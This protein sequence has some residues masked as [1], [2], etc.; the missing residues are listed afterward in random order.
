VGTPVGSPV[1]PPVDS[2][3]SQPSGQPTIQPS[4]PTFAPSRVPTHAPVAPG[5]T[6]V[7]EVSGSTEIGGVSGNSNGTLSS[8]CINAFQTSME[9]TSGAQE[10]DVTGASQEDGVRRRR[11]LRIEMQTST[12]SWIITFVD[13]YY[14]S[15]YPGKNATYLASHYTAV[16]HDAFTSGDFQQLLRDNALLLNVTELLSVLCNNV[17]LTSSVTP[18]SVGPPSHTSTASLTDGQI[19][20]IVIGVVFGTLILFAGAYF[21]VKDERSGS[22]VSAPRFSQFANEQV[23]LDNRSPDRQGGG[24][25]LIDE[26]FTLHMDN[27]GVNDGSNIVTVTDITSTNHL[28]IKL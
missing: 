14:L 22:H 13:T 12:S 28:E 4:A 6:D 11:S 5:S 18:S 17:N 15:N 24:Q 27:E 2:P 8:G 10:V 1:G 23:V 3:S 9:Q 21:Y 19:A 20:G 7:V 26:S 16:I 25:D